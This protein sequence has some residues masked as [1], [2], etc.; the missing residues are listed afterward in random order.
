MSRSAMCRV[1]MTRAEASLALAAPCAAAIV[2]VPVIAEMLFFGV[3]VFLSPRLARFSI[4]RA[5]ARGPFAAC[6]LAML[7]S[8]VGW[9]VHW[10]WRLNWHAGGGPGAFL[11]LL[12][13]PA[14]MLSRAASIY[15]FGT[16]AMLGGVRYSSGWR[17]LSSWALELLACLSAAAAEACKTAAAP[18][19]EGQQV[20]NKEAD[21][22]N[23]RFALPGAQK[24]LDGAARNIKNNDFTYFVGAPL[25]PH[26]DGKY[27]SL[28]LWTSPGAPRACLTAK[29]C[30]AREKGVL[31]L[32]SSRLG[33]RAQSLIR[34][35]ALPAS[36][37]KTLEE[38][39]AQPAAPAP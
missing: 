19:D 23:S 4:V 11:D 5:K 33:V 1:F 10:A 17:L 28:A 3:W 14:E 16:W 9:H 26:E 34:L 30:G 8:L 29:V 2:C 21:T 37:A 20:W 38:N 12:W 35:G 36:L 13:R 18:F 22:E 31:E 24:E 6:F 27:F 32:G 39:M 15:P 7:G 25:Y